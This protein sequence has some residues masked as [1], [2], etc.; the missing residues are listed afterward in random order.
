MKDLVL[1][2]KDIHK[3]KKGTILHRNIQ[4]KSIFINNNSIK[5]GNFKFVKKLNTEEQ[6]ATT[7]LTDTYYMSPEQL[8]DGVF[9]SKTDI[10]A[11]GCLLYEICTFANPFQG[12]NA[13]E[14]GNKIREG[15]IKSLPTIYKRELNRV[16][17]WCLTKDPKDRPSVE[18]LLAIPMINLLIR[19]NRLSEVSKKITEKKNRNPLL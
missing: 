2:L 10:W 13:F 6:F 12:N 19:Q 16:I 17:R 15:K 1:A 9:T 4:P 18:D 5:L 7:I 14:I 11:L 8:E 3:N